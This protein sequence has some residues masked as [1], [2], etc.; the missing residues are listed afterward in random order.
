MS[1]PSQ[2]FSIIRRQC[3]KPE[4]EGRNGTLFSLSNGT[5]GLRAADEEIPG[6]SGAG[7]YLAGTYAN[8]PVSLLGVH[9]PDH[10]LT[11]PDRITPTGLASLDADAIATLPNLPNP[12]AVDLTVGAKQVGRSAVRTLSNERALHMN[13]AT[14]SRC[15][16]FRDEADRR[17]RVDSLRFV[18]CAEPHLICFRYEV[19]RLNHDAKVEVAPRI[20]DS[21]TSAGGVVLWDVVERDARGDGNAVAIRTRSPKRSISIAQT[22]RWSEDRCR[23][24]VF[25]FVAEVSLEYALVQAGAAAETGFE[26]CQDAHRRAFAERAGAGSFAIDEDDRTVEGMTF[27]QMHLQMAMGDSIR[28]AGL[29]VKGLTGEGYR[30]ATFWDADFYMFPYYL[31]TQP[32]QAKG[33]LEYRYSQLD[34]YRRNARQWG[35][36]GAQVPWETQRT[37][38][39]ATAPWLCLQDR[40]IHISADAAYMFSLYDDLTGDREAMTSMGAEF[41]FETARF[42]ASRVSFVDQR[43]RV[44]LRDVGSP[45]QYHTF[46]DNDF[47]I[48]AMARW[49]LRYAAELA[50]R[51]DCKAAAE[52]VGL[53]GQEVRSWANIAERLFIQDP[54]HEGIIQPFDGYF[55]LSP[56]LAG[57]CETNCAHSQAVKQPNVLAAFWP[58]EDHFD[59]ACRR[60]NWRFFASRTLHGSSLSAPSMA[61][62]AGR[63]GLDDEALSLLRRS[64][65]IDLD[66]INGDSALGVHLAS[67]APQWYTVAMGFGGL[68]PTPQCLRFRPKLPRQWS[69]LA[70]TCCWRFQRVHVGLTR[71]ALT[72]RADATN[73]STVNVAAADAEPVGLHPGEVRAWPTTAG[74]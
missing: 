24:D 71:E 72:V 63:C 58:F 54:N 18:S 42:Y 57:I 40:E 8:G 5:L 73:D 29:P 22:A 28:H 62:M 65:R 23:L 68:T 38:D 7:L 6:T 20:D 37:G 34:A 56:D 47:F 3:T 33:L 43:G 17:T 49:N 70:F 67:A 2:R 45:D 9:D 61:H 27:G 60:A 16:I 21:V 74:G 36:R 55:D 59:L 66:D 26:T 4:Q 11:H 15:F 52:T 64:A 1:E 39:E 30:F 32:R 19:R 25:V 41:I 44:E 69:H 51:A 50:G 14:V 12:L 53:T 46:V 31:L 48:S 35:Y 10:I 13:E